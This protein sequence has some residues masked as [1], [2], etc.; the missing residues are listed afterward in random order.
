MNIVSICLLI[1]LFSIGQ[2]ETNSSYPHNDFEKVLM[3]N[4]SSDFNIHNAEFWGNILKKVND[5]GYTIIV[6]NG[7]SDFAINKLS[8]IRDDHGKSPIN[9]KYCFLKLLKANDYTYIIHDKHIMIIPKAV[10][11]N[12]K[13]MRI[14]D[15]KFLFGNVGF[16]SVYSKNKQIFKLDFIPVYGKR[17]QLLPVLCPIKNNSIITWQE[18]REYIFSQSISGYEEIKLN[19][20][21]LEVDN[22][23]TRIQIIIKN[24][25][26]IQQLKRFFKNKYHSTPIIKGK[27]LK[28]NKNVIKP[29]LQTEIAFYRK[30]NKW[31]GDFITLGKGKYKLILYGLTNRPKPYRCYEINIIE[32][33]IQTNQI[34][35]NLNNPVLCKNSNHENDG[36]ETDGLRV[37]QKRG[38][39]F[40]G[41]FMIYQVQKK[42]STWGQRWTDPN[43]KYS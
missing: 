4:H 33:D 2:I 8:K 13:N 12:I 37:K 40:L 22:K 20:R 35:I 30:N 17:S 19:D 34:V 25:I 39:V 42:P 21:T 11:V 43:G 31:Q 7:K 38:E 10:K 16:V 5:S 28:Y 1:A 23:R 24:D 9:Y 32:K 27:I 14:V 15:V 36:E 29:L 18:P 3:K 26:F 41:D 6:Y